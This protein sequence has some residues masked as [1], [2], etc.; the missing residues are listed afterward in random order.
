MRIKYLFLIVLFF[1]S[2]LSGVSA[3]DG[4]EPARSDAQT[5]SG[6]ILNG[7]AKTLVKPAYPAAAKAVKAQGA[8][9]VQVT[10]DEQGNVISATA[11]SGHPLLR[12]AA[13]TAARASKFLP[14]LLGGKPVKVSG[15][16]VY[17][18]VL[19]QNSERIKEYE[20]LTAMGMVMFLTALKEIPGDPETD[21]ILLQ[22]S[23]ELPASM[24][25][26]KAM[27][28]KLVRAKSQSARAAAIDEII[29]SIRK[30][31]TGTDAWMVDLGK[32][33]GDAIGEAFKISG[34]NYQLDRKDFI[35]SLQGMS[36]LLESPPKEISE[37]SLTRIRAIASYD[38]ETDSITPEFINDFFKKSLEFIEYMVGE[39]K[40]K[41]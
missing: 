39:S 31:L 16:I 25:T 32:Q 40:K 30:N 2:G 6:G 19:P 12:A 22:L 4:G 11:V 28:Q 36:W 21:E 10:I 26:D 29:A 20:Q 33:W 5:I 27:F 13:V 17:N 23:S 7:K 34:S 1:S 38:T 15:V 14:T 24:R 18:F 37:E 35:K 3:Q 8:V 41:R 9:N